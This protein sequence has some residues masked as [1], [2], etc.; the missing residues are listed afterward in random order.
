MLHLQVYNLTSE[1]LPHT[2][3]KIKIFLLTSSFIGSLLSN[4]NKQRVQMMMTFQKHR[5]YKDFFSCSSTM[6]TP[7]S[8]PINEGVRQW[9]FKS[10]IKHRGKKM[11]SFFCFI[12]LFL[13]WKPKKLKQ[14]LNIFH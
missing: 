1:Y 4:L 8:Q 10:R 14:Q 13:F 7:C 5:I 12:V 6:A 11:M 2:S 9:F 3:L